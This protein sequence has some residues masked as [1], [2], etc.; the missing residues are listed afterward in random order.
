MNS[1]QILVVDDHQEICSLVQKILSKAGYTVAT[2]NSGTHALELLQ[3]HTFDLIVSDIM[4]PDVDGL[5]LL[6]RAKTY[7]PDIKVILITAYRS[8]ETV[9]AALR[10]GAYDYITKPFDAEELLH[11]VNRAMDYQ[12]VT[13]EKNEL[14]TA[15]QRQL[16]I[17]NQLVEASQHIANTLDQQEVLHTVLKVALQVSPQADLSAIYY[18]DDNDG[19]LKSITLPRDPSSP[20]EAPLDEKAIEQ[21]LRQPDPYY[22]PNWISPG[23][24]SARSLFIQ[25]LM[26][27]SVTLGALALT[28]AAPH[29]FDEDFQQVISM[30]ANQ[31]TI[32]LQN[33]RLYAEARRADELEALYEAG[34]ALTRTLNLQETLITTMAITRSLTGAS[35]SNIYLYADTDN[36][37]RIDSVIT[38]DDHALQTD[39][40]RRKSAAIAHQVIESQQA[41]LFITEQDTQ[42]PDED[43]NIL[44]RLAVPLMGGETPIGVLEQA[45]EHAH[46]FG[47]NDVRLMQI[48]SSQAAAAIEN[49]RLYE[50]LQQRLQQ[51][52]ALGVISQSISNTLNLQRV[53]ELVVESAVQTIPVATHST[54]YLLDQNQKK[55][56]PEAEFTRDQKIP[57]QALEPVREKIIEAATQQDTTSRT[58]WVPP[59]QSPWSLL[60]APL[61]ANETNIGAICIESPRRD[62]FHDNDVALLNTFASHASVAIQNANLFRELSSAYLDLAHKQEEILNNTRTLQALFDSITDGLYIV[63]K[64]MKIVIINQAEAKRLGKTTEEIIGQPC[65]DHLWGEAAPAVISLVRETLQTGKEKNWESQS[66]PTKRGPFTDRDVRTYPIFGLT[67]DQAPSETEQTVTQV[68]IFAQDVSE[69]RRLQASLFRSANLATVGQLAASIAHQINNPLTVIIANTQLMEMD[70]PPASPDYPIITDILEAG[71]HIRHIVQNLLDFSTQDTYDWFETNIEETLKEALALVAHSLRKSNINVNQ[72]FG[73]VP[74]VLASASHLKLLWMNLLLNARDAISERETTGDPAPEGNNLTIQ[75]TALTDQQV[76]I[77]IIDNGNGINEKHKKNLFQPFF[78][79]KSSGKHVGLGLFTCDAIVEAHQGRITLKNNTDGKGTT[80]TVTLPVDRHQ[81]T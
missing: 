11:S 43:E 46:L 63:D 36:R 19:S 23:H 17:R 22:Q 21:K 9:I 30:L 5:E 55:F 50:E 20:A 32:A 69:K 59:D 7:A 39:A 29:A 34:K 49:A 54:L 75:T 6:K 48:I 52:E 33:A 38:L 10:Q 67:P 35:V 40:D 2:S 73:P 60:V 53:L 14:L 42:T 12:R 4:M 72:Q 70:T 51:T 56:V 77:K 78:T 1:K 25:P 57:P 44:C 3:H 18:R 26:L 81:A 47:A 28:S 58:N 45:S 27:S 8:T 79:T 61:K 76:Q 13:S 15:L 37:P 41:N 65:D 31:T 16:K 71:T 24:D 80:V 62:G 64:N 74:D 66:P 68:I